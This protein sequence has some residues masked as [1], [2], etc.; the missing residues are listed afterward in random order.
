MARIDWNEDLR[1]EVLL[2]LRRDAGDDKARCH[3]SGLWLVRRWSEGFDL[4]DVFV[5]IDVDLHGG[6]TSTAVISEVVFALRSNV[7]KA[8]APPAS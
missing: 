6:S 3:G 5:V 7:V 1:D 2:A 4:I 8:S